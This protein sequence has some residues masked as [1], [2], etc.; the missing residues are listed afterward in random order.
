[1]YKV[2]ALTRARL[3]GTEYTVAVDTMETELH[4][5]VPKYDNK[6]YWAFM[7][8]SRAEFYR[9]LTSHPVSTIGTILRNGFDKAN[10][11]KT[12]LWRCLP[13][14]A[15]M[16]SKVEAG[17]GKLGL[18]YR[19]TLLSLI[20]LVILGTRKQYRPIIVL[21]AIYIYFAVLS[22]FTVNTGN[23]IFLPGLIAWAI[24][25]AYPIL[26]VF[27]LLR[28]RVGTAWQNRSIVD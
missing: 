8:Y 13:N 24:L 7:H 20:G 26:S 22:G 16:I 11:S 9:L 25:A 21:S 2:A 14:H 6:V 23:R 5:L 18:S 27:Y 28:N 17:I 4:L 1:M 12:H 15:S 19:V 10:S 3:N